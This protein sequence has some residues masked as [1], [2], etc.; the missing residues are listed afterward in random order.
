[1]ERKSR[2]HE[3]E[4]VGHTAHTIR[5]QKV[6]SAYG[7]SVHVLLFAIVQVLSLENGATQSGASSQS[8]QFNQAVLIS[9]T[10]PC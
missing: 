9:S 1:M 8:K 4:V 6:M 5:R 2:W 7:H 10:P 3:P